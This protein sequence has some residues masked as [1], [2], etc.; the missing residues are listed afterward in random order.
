M[1]LLEPLPGQAPT[2]WIGVAMMVTVPLAGLLVAM[3]KWY[4]RRAEERKPP[5][6]SCP[7][8]QQIADAVGATLPKE[9]EAH[10]RAQLDARTRDASLASVAGHAAEVMEAL[11]G[12]NALNTDGLLPR[13]SMTATEVHAL[14][15]EML[16]R[17]HRRRARE[18]V[19]GT[20]PGRSPISE[21]MTPRR[22][23]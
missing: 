5:A 14:H 9:I 6:S 22:T 17:Q 21:D 3:Q 13:L 10:V 1:V 2:T 19:E 18:E 16:D 11:R 12:H 15:E 23:R 4:E 8:P 20:N 7:T